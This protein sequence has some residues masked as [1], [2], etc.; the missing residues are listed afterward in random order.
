M[1]GYKVGVGDIGTVPCGA[2]GSGDASCGDDGRGAIRQRNRGILNGHW[3]GEHDEGIQQG[4]DRVGIGD[5]A[6][7]EHGACCFDGDGAVR[8]DG[9]RGD[10]VGVGDVGAVQGGARGSG[11]EN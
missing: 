3:Q 7:G 6:R 10:R 5:G 11:D 9:M 2:R 4:G 8:T 1:R